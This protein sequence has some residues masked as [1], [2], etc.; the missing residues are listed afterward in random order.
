MNTRILIQQSKGTAYIQLDTQKC[1]ACWKC[2]EGCKKQVIGRIDLPWHKHALIVDPGNCSGCL[3]CVTACQYNA[4]SGIDKAKQ[5]T[6]SQKN[7]I[8]IS[9]IINNLLLLTGIVMIFSGLILQLGFHAGG[10][11]GPS[12]DVQIFSS[13]PV[14]YEQLR[15]INTDKVVYGLHYKEWSV[16]HK[17]AIVFFSLLMGY[18]IYI[19]CKWYKSVIIKHQ[20]RKNIQLITLSVLFILVAFTGLVPWFIDLSGS[21]NI[22]RLIFIEIHDKLA[23]I[24]VVYML[25]HF[26]GRYNWFYNTYSKRI[27]KKVAGWKI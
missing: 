23:L 1:K 17:Y 12:H 6:E 11:R 26:T 20:L 7:K 3:N 2:I 22:L 10:D 24:L 18:H 27:R 16:T 14:Q 19:H 9:F 21:P 8:L 13:Q 4:L 5:E 15:K 25:F